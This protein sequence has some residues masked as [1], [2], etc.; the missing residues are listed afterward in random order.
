MNSKVFA[1][2]SELMSRLVLLDGKSI[3]LLI[4]Q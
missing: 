2:V 1:I 4:L 3:I